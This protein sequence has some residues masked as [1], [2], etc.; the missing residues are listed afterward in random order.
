LLRNDH[1]LWQRAVERLTEQGDFTVAATIFWAARAWLNGPVF[2]FDDTPDP[3]EIA[4]LLATTSYRSPD[5]RAL[6]YV[7]LAKLELLHGKWQA[8]QTELQHLAALNDAWGKEYRAFFCLTPFI[9]PKSPTLEELR[10][11]LRRW[12]ASSVPES[13]EPFRTLAAHNGLHAHLRPYLLGMLSARL[14]HEK[15]ARQYAIELL[16]MPH[17]K[18][19]GSLAHDL[20]LSVRAE[21]ARLR[22]QPAQALALLERQKMQVWY[23]LAWGSPC[24][25]QILAR[26]QRAE[27]LQALGRYEEAL[28]W[29]NTTVCYPPDWILLAPNYLKRAE[30]YEKLGQRENAIEQYLR[31]LRLWK[32]CDPEL[33]PVVDEA[34][35][36]LISLQ[37]K[38]FLRFQ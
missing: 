13:T 9:Q 34:Q 25:A 28:N 37:L 24:Y 19:L 8:A 18:R 22:G 7:Y 23:E 33:R 27:V 38:P 32:D 26:F 6:A 17:S 5:Y 30:V 20:A 15:E 29:Y 3:A 1:V 21:L 36:K 31:F 35:R 16:A 14:Q 11:E 10:D 2:H 4:R 12:D